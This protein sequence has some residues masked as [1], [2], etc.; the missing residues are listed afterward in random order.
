MA[1]DRVIKV[2]DIKAQ[3]CIQTIEAKDFPDSHDSKPNAIWFDAAARQLL[4]AASRPIS[5]TQSAGSTA[6]LGHS[7]PLVA[8]LSNATFDLVPFPKTC[9][10]YTPSGLKPQQLSTSFPTQPSIWDDEVR[11]H[12]RQLNAQCSRGEDFFIYLP[13]LHTLFVLYLVLYVCTACT[14]CLMESE[15]SGPMRQR[16]SDI[17]VCSL[18]GLR[19]KIRE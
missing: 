12:L 10:V 1:A 16:K 3:R 6:A 5:W 14:P 18:S 7:A 17:L 19:I 8:A 11:R 9:T 15:S 4:T 2:W 13:T